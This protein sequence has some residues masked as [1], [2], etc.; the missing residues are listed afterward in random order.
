MKVIYSSRKSSHSAVR[1]SDFVLAPFSQGLTVSWAQDT[2]EPLPSNPIADI[3]EMKYLLEQDYNKEYKVS[4]HV[5]PTA[6]KLSMLKE[7]LSATLHDMESLQKPV[8]FTSH[9]PLVGTAPV[10]S[11]QL[12]SIA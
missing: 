6:E 8:L 1:V 11:L 7:M 3:Q 12:G 4:L 10:S 5:T 9:T 2:T